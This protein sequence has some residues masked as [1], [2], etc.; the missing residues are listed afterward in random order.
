MDEIALLKRLAEQYSQAELAARLFTTQQSVSRWI[1]GHHEPSGPAK[2]L[3]RQ[4]ASESGIDERQRI[5][6]MGYVGG[7]GDVD[8][9]FEQ[10]PPDGLEQIELPQPIGLMDDPVGFIVRGQS[11][12]PRYSD[13][14]IALVER[15]Q[16]W[17]TDRMIGDEAV[18]L[19]YEADS[20]GKR[21][22]KRIM[23]GPRQH[24][25]N[26]VSLNGP[27]MEGVRI[28]WASPVRVILPNIG[29]R[30]VPAAKPSRAGRR[31]ELGRQR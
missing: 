14:D 17:P 8:P 31:G 24:T 29:L 5:P 20:A 6:I 19:T 23:P 9:D 15:E 22:L 7:G 26:L 13:G 1:L 12:M 2:R 21:Y 18:V 3:I 4:L 28:R 25:F 10:V 27:T 16:P 30:R 11:M